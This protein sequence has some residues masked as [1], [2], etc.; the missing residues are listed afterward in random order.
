MAEAPEPKRRNAAKT[1]ARILQAAFE[2]FASRGYARTGMREIADHAGVATSLVVRYFGAK[3]SLFEEALVHGIYTHS[4]FVQ[5]KRNFG[6]AMVELI[7]SEEDASL[8]AMMVL[9]VADPESKAVAQKVTRNLV[10]KS[11]AEWLGPPNAQARALNMLALLNG[12]MLQTRHLSAEPVTA[13]STR[14]LAGALQAIVD[15]GRI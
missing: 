7:V 15:E 6:K 10:A 1:R 14:W 5:D 2:L 9:A 4:L 11:L 12:F 8:P 3:S 13:A